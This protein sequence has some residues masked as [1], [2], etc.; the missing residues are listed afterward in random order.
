[1]E[2]S[3][4]LQMN[5]AACCSSLENLVAKPDKEK[6]L[7]LLIVINKR[8]PR[9]IL[10]YRKDW[11]VPI[12]DDSIQITFCPFCGSKLDAMMLSAI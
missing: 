6:G 10:E 3:V 1:M 4:G 8:G 2:A 5:H 7:G 9:F 11:A 12:A